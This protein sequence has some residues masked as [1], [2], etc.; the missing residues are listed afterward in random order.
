MIAQR[1]ERRL[2]EHQPRDRKLRIGLVLANVVAWFLIVVA[3]R[4]IFF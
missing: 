2:P 1:A 4:R 3:I